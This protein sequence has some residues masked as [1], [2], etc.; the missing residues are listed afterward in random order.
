MFSTARH[1]WP[2]ALAPARAHPAGARSAAALV[3]IALTLA[4]SPAALAAPSSSP[5]ILVLEAHVEARPEELDRAI[6]RFPALID[7]AGPVGVV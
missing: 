7:A 2:S 3:A 1:A 6:A 4:A 5:P